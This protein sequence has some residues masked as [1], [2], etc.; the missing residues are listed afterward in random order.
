MTWCVQ[1]RGARD[2]AHAASTATRHMWVRVVW[3]VVVVVLLGC[4]CHGRGYGFGEVGSVG[5]CDGHDEVARG[6]KY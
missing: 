4:Y 3:V 1:L 5:S 2:M 6:W